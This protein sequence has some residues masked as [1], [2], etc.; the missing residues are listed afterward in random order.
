MDKE[1]IE[2]NKMI[3]EFLELP[4]CKRC[5]DCGGYDFDNGIIWRPDQMEYHSS[6]DWLMPVVEKAVNT[7]TFSTNEGHILISNLIMS[8]QSF[9]KKEI[10]DCLI[11][12]IQWYNLQTTNQTHG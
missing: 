9:D 5:T 7:I 1:I 11:E 10:F 3:A 12:Y 6:F 2:G 4:K 8:I